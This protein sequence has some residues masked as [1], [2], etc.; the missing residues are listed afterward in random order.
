MSR[1]DNQRGLARRIA[2]LWRALTAK[3]E[4]RRRRKDFFIKPA[5]YAP[6]PLAGEEQGKERFSHEKKYHV[7]KGTFMATQATP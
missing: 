2:M 1:N 4:D 5:L 3:G 7:N 6:I